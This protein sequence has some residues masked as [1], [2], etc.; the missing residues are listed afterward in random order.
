MVRFTRVVSVLIALAAAAYIASPVGAYV[1]AGKRKKI[2]CGILVVPGAAQ[3]LGVGTTSGN[4]GDLFYLLDRREDLK[5]AGWSLENPLAPGSPSTGLG[6]NYPNYWKIDLSAVRSLS[7]MHLLYLPAS[8]SVRLSEENREKLRQFVDGGGVLW[9]DNTGGSGARLD[10]EDTFFIVD[11][12]FQQASGTDVVASRHHPLLTL[13]FWLTEQDVAY[14][15]ANA[16]TSVCKPGYDPAQAVWGGTQP[17]NFDVL[18]PVVMNQP[19]TGNAMPSVAANHYGSGRVVATANFVGRGC[20]QYPPF[21]SPSIKFAFNV[22]AWAS[23]WTHLRKDPRHSGNSIDTVGGT[24]LLEMWS[25]PLRSSPANKIESAPVLYKNVAFYS[26]GSRLFAL[27]VMPQEDLDQDGNPDDGMLGLAGMENKGQD[28]I[29][30]WDDPDGAALSAPSIVTAQDPCVPNV[31]FEAVLVMSAAGKVHMLYAFPTDPGDPMGRRLYGQTSPVL[32][33]PWDLGAPVTA[34]SPPLYQNG[35][36]YAVSG[37]GRLH[38]YNPS[39]ACWSSQ[40]PGRQSVGDKWQVPGATF[41]GNAEFRCGPT[42]G[43]VKNATSGAVTGMIYWF[44]G[45]WQTGAQ[46]QDAEQNDFVYGMPIFVAND[47]LKV[48]RLDS[49]GTKAECR[50]AYREAFMS[51]SP[52]PRAWIDGVQANV[53]ANTRLQN[54]TNP[55]N[56]RGYVI[57]QS[58][59]GTIPPSAV[60]YATYAVDYADHQVGFGDYVTNR[61]EV[62]TRLRVPLEPR[63]NGSNGVEP[64]R[65]VGMPAMGPDSMLFLNGERGNDRAGGTVYGLK[66]DGSTQYTRWSYHLHSGLTS[67]DVQ[68]ASGENLPIPGV[69]LDEKTGAAMSNPK[70]YSSPAVSGDKVFVTVTGAGGGGPQAALACFKANADFVIRITESAGSGLQSGQERKPKRLINE[71]TGREM[72]VKIWQPNLIGAPSAGI[73]VTPL[74]AAVPV[75]RDM[76][77][78]DRGV[79][80]FDNFDRL[81]LRGGTGNVMMTNTFSPSLP[82]W[83]FLD[84]VEVPIDF[85]TWAP[86]R[87]AASALN[88]AI[89]ESRS[90]SVDLGG[91]NNL[92]WY[93]IVDDHNCSGIHSSPVVIGDLV[94]FVCDDGH[95]YA[96][97]ADGGGATGH[98]NKDP[99]KQS[100]VWD[101]QVWTSGGTGGGSEVNLSPAGSNGVLLIPGMDGL[102]AYS[103]ATTLVA[104]SNRI[105]ELD[106]AGDASW[107]IDNINYPVAPPPGP[108][109]SPPATSI[110]VNKPSR[111]RYLEGGEILVVNSG[112]NQ[113]F[114]IDK[115]GT[116]GI[117]RTR[118]RIGGN[119]ATDGYVRWMWERFIDPGRLLRPGQPTDIKGPTD[120]LFWQE[121]DQG[122][123]VYHCLVSDSGNHRVLDLVYRVKVDNR[124][125]PEYLMANAGPDPSTGFYLPELN[126]V[127][128]TDSTNERYVYECIQLVPNVDGNGVLLGQDIWAAVSN[129]RTGTDPAAIRNQGLGGAVI[130]LK[131]RNVK[132]GGGWDYNDPK[133]GRIVAACDRVNWGGEKPLAGP[134]FFQVMDKPDGRYLLI[135]DNYGV[136]AAGPLGGSA[137]PVVRSFTDLDYRMIPRELR[138]DGGSIVVDPSTNQPCTAG[139]GIPLLATSVHELPNGRW[140]ITNGFAGADETAGRSF[141][142]EVFEV[143]LTGATP[144][145]KWNAPTLYLSAQFKG[146]SDC[147]E[148]MVS[149]VGPPIFG[150]GTWKQKMQ[151]S[152]ILQQPR[153]AFRQF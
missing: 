5:P 41:Q 44:A 7:R 16:G 10:F 1:Y 136:Y 102:H 23:S 122:R 59:S 98:I 150:S 104:D 93:Y 148:L 25:L 68:G 69:I 96:I 142:G 103:N 114:K 67:T 65:I 66:N 91:W 88:L 137:P 94:F 110:A 27:D 40:N 84:N 57:I 82:V 47:R 49:T 35:W 60:I 129:Y 64:T 141:S 127:T 36:L 51:N 133:T 30:I 43:F 46:P 113:V 99:D 81:K 76:I 38:A 55:G 134:R 101:T 107:M 87:K 83:V 32:S 108:D 31:T 73:S 124:G 130:A 11:F 85:S 52:Q 115:S 74:I 147:R 143:D 120:A 28:I 39:I 116:V 61:F 149:G 126:W 146:F 58:T 21:D 123:M 20:Y 3:P 97:P 105:V 12:E 132:T 89:P 145:I 121:Y 70:V 80:S 86:T 37:Q 77:D 100:H 119:P 117:A 139:L 128:Y 18:Y 24:K 152:Y 90:A 62:M 50:I 112:S 72:Q 15:G 144:M 78:Y 54:E 131:Y 22:M 75:P 42:Y 79:I 95:A 53:I 109:K 48:E 92:L 140:L 4:V 13:P 153:C 19:L 111:A 6:K 33:A 56:D 9:I 71:A 34:P 135:C 63:A 125:N 26:A 45:P 29:W 8:G 2:N 14:L 118:V 138:N 106:G 17:L 151:K